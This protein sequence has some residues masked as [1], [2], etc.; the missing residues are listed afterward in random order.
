MQSMKSALLYGFLVW[1][2]PFI[3][4]VPFYTPEGEPLIDIFLFKTIMILVGALAGVGLLV[5]YFKTV[6]ENYLRESVR[7]GGLWLVMNWALD[8]AVLLQL[9]PMSLSAYFGEI[10]LRYLT[11]P[12]ISIGMG[13]LLENR[14]S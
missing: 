4:A 1:L 5:R 3:A 10:G 14:K 13:Y 11:I 8:F 7:I 6:T 12:I 9:N 2:I